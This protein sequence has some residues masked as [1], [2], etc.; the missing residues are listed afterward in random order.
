MLGLETGKVVATTVLELQQGDSS[1]GGGSSASL[2]TLVPSEF[3]SKEEEWVWMAKA[4]SRQ[5]RVS[6]LIGL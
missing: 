2:R 3:T 4:T 5:S 1:V 6:L